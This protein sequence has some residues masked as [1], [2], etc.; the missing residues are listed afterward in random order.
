M[1]ASSSGLDNVSRR[2]RPLHPSTIVGLDS[3]G[4][5]G[6]RRL[7]PRFDSPERAFGLPAE[8]EDRGA[9]PVP[10]RAGERHKA[11]LWAAVTAIFTVFTI[12]RN[13]NARV[14]Q[15]VLGTNDGSIAV[16]DRLA[17]YDWIAAAGRQICWSHLRRD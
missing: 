15:A 7:P 10:R 12:A 17:S 1:A 14:A 6:M 3:M 9:T 5:E 8:A 16:T 11:W 4:W 13:R 2:H